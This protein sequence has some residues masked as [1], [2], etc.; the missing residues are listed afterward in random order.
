MLSGLGDA[1]KTVAAPAATIGT[2]GG[3]L[4]LDV[5]Q[6]WGSVARI[7]SEWDRFA[8]DVGCDI[9]LSPIWCRVWWQ[10]YGRGS[11][12]ILTVRQ[13]NDAAKPGS[14]VAV[15]PLFISQLWLGPVPLRIAKFLSS[16]STIVVLSPPVLSE[17]AEPCYQL[18]IAYLLEEAGCHA[19]SF[20]PLGGDVERCEP[21]RRACNVPSAPAALLRERKIGVHTVFPLPMS[22]ENYLGS[23]GKMFR[24]NLRRNLNG[25][26]KSF[27]FE[28]Q[29]ID[30]PTEL[31]THFPAFLQMHT[32]QWN[33][34]GMLGHFGDWPQASS[35][36]ETLVQQ[37]APLGRVALVCLTASGRPISYYWNFTFGQRAF[38]RLPA[39][40]S[41]R[42][43][44]KHG[45]GRVGLVKMIEAMIGRGLHSV[46]GG[47]GHYDYKLQ[48]GAVEYPLRSM[49]VISRRSV[50]TRVGGLL[51]AAFSDA[52][53]FAYARAWRG[54][55]I[56]RLGLSYRPF[57]KIWIRT[58]L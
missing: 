50:F 24:S 23:L 4:R 3:T 41:G 33:A 43:W 7:Q 13:G 51:A 8:Q 6:D 52:L 40:E 11:L 44:D 16:D 39:R 42:E 19:I 34:D 15:F 27:G 46:E 55:V 12:C 49:L 57:W 9:Y 26:T 45:L 28:S 56:R 54:K 48:H 21:I 20:G 38:W 22:F 53:H 58:R 25:L 37:L 2:S 35:F 18:A 32:K 5:F 17:L 1:E 36:S 47:P 14:L 29:V 10:Y 30:D 31:G